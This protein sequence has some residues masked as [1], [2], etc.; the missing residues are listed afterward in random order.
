M[1][2]RRLFAFGAAPWCWPDSASV[3]G[4]HRA[5]AVEP[6]ARCDSNIASTEDL[7]R[8]LPGDGRAPGLLLARRQLNDMLAG[9]AVRRPIRS[10]PARHAA[11]RRRC[12]AR[13]AHAVDACPR[14]RCRRCIATGRRRRNSALSCCAMRRGA[15]RLVDLLD[16]LQ[17]LRVATAPCWR[18]RRSISP[19]SSHRRSMPS[20]P[21]S[22]DHVDLD[23]P[24]QPV[25]LLAWERGCGSLWRTLLE[26]PPP[27]ALRRDGAR[28][29][30][31]AP[32]VLVVDDDR[33]G[34]A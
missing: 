34:V 4:E 3:R 32:P 16:G 5:A 25:E 9:S 8:R 6:P 30:D 31:H 11:L 29:L 7:D 33:A 18:A 10:R 24:E 2:D 21:P 23:L 19:S 15:R 26:T 28:E 1:P 22:G 13:A 12:R 17:A 27:R 14:P 20:R